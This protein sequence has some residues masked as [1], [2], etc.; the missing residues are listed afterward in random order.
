MNGNVKRSGW[1][2][3]LAAELGPTVGDAE[4]EVGTVRTNAAAVI[5]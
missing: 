4:V 3:L 5:P 2:A 1:P